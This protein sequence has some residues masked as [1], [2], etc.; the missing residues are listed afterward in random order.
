MK[1]KRVLPLIAVA[2]FLIASMA[3]VVIESHNKREVREN[4]EMKCWRA[5]S[6]Q[7]WTCEQ[8]QKE[9]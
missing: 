1:T 5:T 9:E 8:Q 6:E 2:I 3:A 7:P 4:A